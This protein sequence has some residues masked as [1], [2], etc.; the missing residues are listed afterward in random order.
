MKL[1]NKILVVMATYNGI[2]YLEEQLINSIR[3]QTYQPHEVIICDDA[4]QD[5]TVEFVHNY[6]EKN[7]LNT[8]K[9]LKNE[10]NLGW[11]NNFK[12]GQNTMGRFFCV[13]K[14]KL[15]KQ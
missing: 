9:L 6:I 14:G 4:S 15:K 1:A 11:I 10:T 7:S 13:A 3:N 12:T 8:W 2:R 5:A